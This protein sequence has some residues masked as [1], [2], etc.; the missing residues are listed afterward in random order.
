MNGQLYSCKTPGLT[1]LFLLHTSIVIL[2]PKL[3]H[4]SLSAMATLQH[5]CC[6]YI[7]CPCA[8]VSSVCGQK[9][10]VPYRAVGRLL[11]LAHA[12]PCRY[13]TL[14]QDGDD[15][16]DWRALAGVFEI[17]RPVKNPPRLHNI[18][19][20]SAAAVNPRQ[21]KLHK[22]RFWLVYFYVH[23]S[24]GWYLFFIAREYLL[25]GFQ[26]PLAVF[27]IFIVYSSHYLAS[28][29]KFWV[30][31]H[32]HRPNLVKVRLFH[33]LCLLVVGC[34]FFF[35]Q[36]APLHRQQHHRFVFLHKTPRQHLNDCNELIQNHRKQ[37][38][39]VA[40]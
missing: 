17:C 9:R 33:F 26:L 39:S 12:K 22:A 15:V 10:T 6:L 36:T 19:V 31:Y 34:L 25:F 14:L 30:L 8:S 28:H 38:A 13:H 32:A 16:S 23:C 11:T 37:I 24:T 2:N 20:K 40:G 7:I 3:Q 27:S 5:Y 4:F 21:P 18:S 1:V 35:R 29:S